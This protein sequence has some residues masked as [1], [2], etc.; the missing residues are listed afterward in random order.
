MARYNF[1]TFSNSAPGREAEFNEW[2]DKVHL[3]EVLAI[4][5]VVAARRFKLAGIQIDEA[6]K[7][8]QYLAIYEIEVDDLRTFLAD[9]MARSADGRL[10]RSTALA[11]DAL[12]MF[13]QAM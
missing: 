4:P 5:G 13:W 6:A 12:P 11:P 9:M 2:Y 1:V 10:Q 3:K 8:H 7:K